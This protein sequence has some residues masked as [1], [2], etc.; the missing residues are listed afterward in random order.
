MKNR[1]L[2][3]MMLAVLASIV[4]T[5][6]RATPS[7]VVTQGCTPGV[8]TTDLAAAKKYAKEHNIFY[9]IDCSK[10]K[11]CQWC[12]AADGLYS[13][14]AFKNWSLENGVPIVYGDYWKTARGGGSGDPTAEAAW[15]Y[16]VAGKITG[17]PFLTLVSPDGNQTTAICTSMVRTGSVYGPDGKIVSSGGFPRKGYWYQKASADQWVGLF[18]YL[19]NGCKQIHLF[20]L[21]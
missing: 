16:Y 13:T 21:F 19:L 12:N 7:G 1:T 8:W 11:D 18:N 14:T 5:I 10:S 6:V 3:K 15:S 9:A 20:L 17:W 4:G 2:A